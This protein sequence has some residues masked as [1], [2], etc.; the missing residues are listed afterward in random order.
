MSEPHRPPGH[1]C[2]LESNLHPKSLRLSLLYRY[3]QK[4][5]RLVP[6][7]VCDEDDSPFQKEGGKDADHVPDAEGGEQRLK[8]HML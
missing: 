7:F 4:W 5:Q 3:C 6:E 1:P 8:V 2:L